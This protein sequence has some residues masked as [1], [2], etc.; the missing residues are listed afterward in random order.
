MVENPENGSPGFSS[1]LD[2]TRSISESAG[3]GTPVEGEVTA[4]D[5]NFDTLTYELD[6]DRFLPDATNNEEA[7]PEDDHVHYFTIDQA[8]GQLSLAKKLDADSGDGKYMFHVRA[9]DPS[10]ETAEIEVTV[11]AMQANDA[12]EIMGS[13]LINA[14]TETAVERKRR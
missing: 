8:T 12:P 13:S 1:S 9:I 5:P 2:Y 3:K 10:G 4:T 14:I 6:S 7:T 11:T